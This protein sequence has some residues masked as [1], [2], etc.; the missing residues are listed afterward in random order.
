MKPLECPCGNSNLIA[1]KV[2]LVLFRVPFTLTEDGPEYD[3]HEAEHSEGWD[4]SNE[5]RCRCASCGASYE[6]AADDQANLYL[7]PVDPEE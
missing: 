5:S 2:T 4:Y 3:D 1:E 7:E 6:I